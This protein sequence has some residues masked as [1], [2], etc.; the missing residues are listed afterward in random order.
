MNAPRLLPDPQLELDSRNP[1]VIALENVLSPQECEALIARIEAEKPTAA[2]ITTFG[3]FA[4]RPD[5]RNNTRVMFDDVPLATTLFERV[6][7]SL[8]ERLEEDWVLCGTN[9]RLRCYRYA[10]GEYFRPH[11]DGA[12][13]R[14]PDERS[15]LTFMVYLNDVD[16]GGDTAF[17][18]LELS[19]KPRAGSALLFNHHLLHESTT[20]QRGL[21][22]AVRSDVMYRRDARAHGC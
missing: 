20:L 4:M 12:F 2:P 8:P 14:N 19:V 15:L 9:E 18:D 16:A 22:Y 13:H 21:K 5:I 11:F 6:K 10:P 1:L 17:P 7:R 3:G